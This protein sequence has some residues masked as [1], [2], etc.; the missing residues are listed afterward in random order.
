[1]TDSTNLSLAEFEVSKIKDSV[2][3]ALFC[4]ADEDWRLSVSFKEYLINPQGTPIETVRYLANSIPFTAGKTVVDLGS[5]FGEFAIFGAIVSPSKFLGVEVVGSRVEVANRGA[6]K[7]GLNNVKFVEGDFFRV[8]L[9]SGDIF[10]CFN[11]ILPKDYSV[12]ASL[13]ERLSKSK[14]RI[15]VLTSPL[16]AA[17]RGRDFIKSTTRIDAVSAGSPLPLYVFKT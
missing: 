9:E 3:D 11:S 7:L 12:F 5:G 14:S 1:M 2:S 6:K 17:I 10:Y 13:A 4:T 15:F 8:D 16:A